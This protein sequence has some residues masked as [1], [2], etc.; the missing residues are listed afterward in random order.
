MNFTQ[1]FFTSRRNYGDGDTR[2][3][4][5]DRLW[6]DSITNTI[7]IGDGTPGGRIVSGGGLGSEIEVKFNGSTLT[8]SASSLDFTGSAVAVSNVGSA[9]TVKISDSF[10]V[11]DGGAPATD[12][13]QT[14][15]FDAGGV[16]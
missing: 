4:D 1:D 3:G 6:Y 9:V 13:N 7:R 10:L 5:Q 16:I 15:R 8:A 2:I 12:F 11:F 14:P